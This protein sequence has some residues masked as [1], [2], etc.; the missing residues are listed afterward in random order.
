MS[1]KKD[2]IVCKENNSL[3]NEAF[4]MM[5]DTT[6]DRVFIK[7]VDLVYVKA[8]N[9][10]AKM[11]GKTSENEIIGKTDLDI[12]SDETLAKRYIADDK[13][14]LAGG[15][16]LIDYIEPIPDED[17]QARY[18]TTSKYILRDKTGDV[19]GILGVT[20]DITREY[21]AR[22]HYQQELKY[23]FELPTETY[24]VSYVDVDSWRVISQRRQMLRDAS[25]Q[26]CHT[27]EVLCEAALESIVDKES[28]VY[29]FYTH[30]TK[31]YL[32]KIYAD[33]KTHFE[34]EYQRR[35]SN[36]AV[37]WVKNDVR[38]L[39]DVDNNHL[40]IML[41]ANDINAEKMKEKELL[42]AAQMDRMTNVLNREATM[43][44]I[45]QIFHDE[46]MCLHALFMIDVDNFKRLN[47][48]MGHQTGDEFLIEL[49]AKIKRSFRSSDVVGRIGGDE[50]FVLMRNVS[51]RFMVVKKAKKL[52]DEIQSV[53]EKYSEIKLSASIGISLY[54]ENGKMLEELYAK[55]DQALYE[56]KRAG[57]NQFLFVGSE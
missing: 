22:R 41:S 18:G 30:F 49:T 19:L 24:A 56:A 50:F 17:G 31:E 36:G 48:T 33:G 16:N 5:L 7:N 20:R 1:E 34:F 52:L 2:N 51:D 39:T 45:R 9:S 35:L 38:F 54:P 32:N 53:C 40:C 46:E 57:K 15:K 26:S 14:L 3:I 44:Q 11:V 10:F 8:S 21:Y 13:K 43:D 42:E 25:F 23:L 47:D 4:Q 37:R 55:A 28:R 6:I 27:V 12:F 29:Q